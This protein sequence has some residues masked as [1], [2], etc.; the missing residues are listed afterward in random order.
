MS[1]V[2]ADFLTNLGSLD[3]ETADKQPFGV[4]KL[5]NDGKVLLYNKY[6]SELGKVAVS[7]AEGKIFF[8]RVAPC[9]NNKLFK[10]KFERGVAEG[11]LDTQFNYTFTYK[12]RPTN[13]AVHMY[14]CPQTKTN[15]LFIQK[16]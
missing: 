15:W 8:T 13:V 14:I 10:G 4:V 1:F 7:E 6:E 9:T 12:L 3:R 2:P 16:R 5:D 11:S